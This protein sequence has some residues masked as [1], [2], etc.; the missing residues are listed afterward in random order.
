MKEREI[1]YNIVFEAFNILSIPFLAFPLEIKKQVRKEQG[2]V[3]A[4]CGEEVKKL[5]I[6]H[7]IPQALGGKDTRDNAIGLC[8]DCHR[9]A[10]ELAFKKGKYP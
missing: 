9:I 8:S 2:N 1:F 4:M 5:Q 3:C 7:R 6:H 10:D